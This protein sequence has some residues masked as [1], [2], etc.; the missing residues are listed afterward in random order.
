MKQAHVIFKYEGRFVDLVGEMQ[1]NLGEDTASTVAEEQVVD[2][3]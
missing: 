1:T 3:D 2:K